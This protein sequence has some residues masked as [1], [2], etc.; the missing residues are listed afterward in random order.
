MKI[1]NFTILL[2]LVGLY[3]TTTAQIKPSGPEDYYYYRKGKKVLLNPQT[4]EVF[5]TFASKVN[6][7]KGKTFATQLQ[8]QISTVEQQDVFAPVNA[9]RYK[10]KSRNGAQIHSLQSLNKQFLSNPEVITAYPAFKIGK[11]KVYVGNKITYTLKSNRDSEQVKAF[12]KTNNASLV[13]EIK[14]GDKILF[15]AAIE[16]GGSVF[17]VANGLFEKNLVEYAE[18]DFTFTGYSHYLPNDIF[19]P[20]QWFLSQDSDADI[21]APEAWDIT[22][23]SSSAVV[24]VMDGH[25]YDVTHPDLAEKIVNPYNAVNDNNSPLPENEFANH[26]TPCAGIIAASTNNRTGI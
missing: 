14:L 13:E 2:C 12:L 16:K 4:D 23:G 19:Y 20:S 26:G 24:A 1:K 21:D 3:L 18:P 8:N 6:L 10:V 22:P 7:V 25:G 11:E 17:K 5:V 15:V 9:V